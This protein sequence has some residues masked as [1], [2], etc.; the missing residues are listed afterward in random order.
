VN[1]RR[2]LCL[3]E[4]L[5]FGLDPIIPVKTNLKVS[6]LCLGSARMHLHDLKFIKHIFIILYIAS[7]LL[8]TLCL[9]HVVLVSA[10]LKPTFLKSTAFSD[11]S[12]GPVCCDCFTVLSLV[13][14]PSLLWLFYCALIGQMAQS[15]VIAFLCSDW[16]D[17]PVCCDCI[18]VL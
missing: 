5:Q 11:W 13:R 15:V 1:A 18:S 7:A 2:K 10:S 17:G 6:I 12:D 4:R 16:S 8:F 9:K 14:W 3:L